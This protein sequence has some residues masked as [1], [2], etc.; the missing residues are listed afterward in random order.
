LMR[1]R[2]RPGNQGPVPPQ[3]QNKADIK[4]RIVQSA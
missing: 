2:F 4:K 3:G 1:L